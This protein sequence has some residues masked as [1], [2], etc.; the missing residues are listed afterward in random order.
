[1][2]RYAI[3]SQKE[4]DALFTDYRERPKRLAVIDESVCIGCTKCIQACPFD[5]IIGAAKQMHTVMSQACIGCELCVPL[6]PV[7][8]IDMVQDNT[9]TDTAEKLDRAQDDYLKRTQRLN[10]AKTKKALKQTQAQKI[11][12]RQAAIK[13]AVQRSKQKKQQP[14]SNGSS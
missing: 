4:I 9:S 2:P 5:S 10:T 14:F 3:K 1:M 13:A 7:D 11:A 12:L 8:C 6:C